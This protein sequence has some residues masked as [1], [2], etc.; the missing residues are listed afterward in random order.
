MDFNQKVNQVFPGKV[1]RK[2]LVHKVKASANVPGIVFH[3][4]EHQKLNQHLS[5]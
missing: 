3:Y 5:L 1:V 2:D 4:S